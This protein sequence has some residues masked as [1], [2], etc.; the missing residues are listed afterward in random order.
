MSGADSVA[1]P[2][3]DSL[4]AEARALRRKTHDTIR[5]VTT[6]IEERL[7]LNTAVAAI[8]ELV[9]ELQSATA[10]GGGPQES[11]AVQEGLETLLLLLCPFA[12]HL[13]SEAWERLGKAGLLVQQTWPRC[14][15]KFLARETVTVVVQVNGKRRGSMELA[16]EASE[17]EVLVRA[18]AHE[19]VAAHLKGKTVRRVVHVPGKLI[20]LVVS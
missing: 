16:P 1:E 4:S 9:N 14:Q 5:R 13:T 17:D 15:E 12:P 10:E 7:H 19:G 11:Y 6:D 20:N 2:A 3:T 8:M 18:R